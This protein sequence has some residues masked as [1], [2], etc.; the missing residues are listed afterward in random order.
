MTTVMPSL[1]H[2]S[3]QKVR[4][5]AIQFAQWC[6]KPV[7][8]GLGHSSSP[9]TVP[10]KSFSQHLHEDL[11]LKKVLHNPEIAGL[12]AIVAGDLLTDH[13]PTT[14]EG[15]PTMS[16]DFP[17]KLSKIRRVVEVLKEASLIPS[18]AEYAGYAL[19]IGVTMEYGLETWSPGP[20][21]W[22]NTG[23]RS[24]A[25]EG[26]G[27]VHMQQSQMHTV[28]E[29]EGLTATFSYFRQIGMW[30]FKSLDACTYDVMKA[31]Q[32]LAH[33][34]EFPWYT[35]EEGDNCKKVH[36][37]SDPGQP[38]VQGARVGYDSKKGV[39]QRILALPRCKCNPP[40]LPKVRLRA[41]VLD[42]A[43]KIKQKAQWILQQVSPILYL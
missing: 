24:V 23:T 2:P 34:D 31:I 43:A 32:D 37:S 38:K 3:V 12:L 1:Y 14:V 26:D 4:S 18:Y 30:E 40:P 28:K 10:P 7:Q 16:Q 33:Q 39:T 36:E 11:R 35:C 15:C 13:L 9:K 21:L 29:N 41:T 8:H 19:T 25:A 42:E 20:F 27:S 17:Q 6:P 22:S 5:Q